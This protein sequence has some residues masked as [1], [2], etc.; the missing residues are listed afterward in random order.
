MCSIRVQPRFVF[1]PLFSIMLLNA[2]I[3]TGVGIGISYKSA[4]FVFNLRRLEAI[5]KLE[6]M[7]SMTS[8]LPMTLL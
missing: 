5:S 3:G 4:S 6:Q 8:C 1:H 7:L 2:S